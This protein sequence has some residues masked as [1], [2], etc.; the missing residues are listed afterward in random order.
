MRFG[1]VVGGLLLASAGFA[2]AGASTL[3]EVKSRG[4]LHCGTNP[5]LAGFSLPTIEGEWAGFDTDFCRAIASAVLGDPKAVKFIPLTS[6][7]RFTALQ[8]G[9]VDLLSR[10]TTWTFSRDVQLG[11]EFVGVN[12]YDGQGFLVRKDLGV[13]SVKD[14]DG[15]RICID[16]G[17]TTELNLADYFRTHGLEF[18]SVVVRG[19]D[20]ARTNYDADACDT[21]TTD[22]SA[23]ASIRASLP[24]PENHIILDELISKEPLGI[25][26]RQGDSQWADIV[27]WTLNALVL[28]EELGVTSKNIETM[29]V[30]SNPEIKRLLGTEGEF[31]DQ[32]GLDKEW[33]ARAIGDMGNYGEIFEGNVG[34]GSELNLERGLNALWSD[35][36]IL[37]APPLR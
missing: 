27:R 12:F 26:V 21:Y 16:T 5:G 4:V 25:I 36:G 32:L 23:L 9:E 11:L 24:D 29:K 2:S 17:T 18:D 28:A 3:E 8:S 31:G 6:L 15:A 20:D 22:A 33:A 30:S 10:N 37:F 7:E 13:E 1:W 35:G 19:A 34:K 14:L